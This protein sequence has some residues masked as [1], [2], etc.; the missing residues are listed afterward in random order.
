[1][2]VVPDKMY[3]TKDQIDKMND[4]KLKINKAFLELVHNGN[5]SIEIAELSSETVEINPVDSPTK[6]SK[7]TTQRQL[8]STRLGV[9]QN[10]SNNLLKDKIKC[11]EYFELF[12]DLSH[13]DQIEELLT[14]VNRSMEDTSKESLVRFKSNLIKL[15]EKFDLGE[16][17]K[18]F[19]IENVKFLINSSNYGDYLDFNNKILLRK[20][21]SSVELKLVEAKLQSEIE[22]EEIKLNDEIEKRTKY[23]IDALRRKHNYDEFILTY[24]KMLTEHGKLA[25]ILKNSLSNGIEKANLTNRSLILDSSTTSNKSQSALGAFNLPINSL[26]LPQIFSKRQRK[27]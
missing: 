26:F 6:N 21:A 4:N 25:E 23:K 16:I 19:R 10:S 9:N 13:S 1:M 8:R 20:V 2:A 11:D 18:H 14:N 5:S 15:V 24:L 3:I 17:C 7:D 22:C 12:F 27:K